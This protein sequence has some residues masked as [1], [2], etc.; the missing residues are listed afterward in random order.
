MKNLPR[1]F[2][3][4]LLAVC[5]F[6][7]NAQSA[8]DSASPFKITRSDPALDALIAPD[9]KLKTIASGFGFSDGPVWVRGQNGAPGYLLVS[10]IIRKN[11][12]QVWFLA[13]H[14]VNVPQVIAD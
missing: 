6:S 2:F 3:C 1:A 14:L 13:E 10:S 5:L 8:P 12:A 9:A 4:S 11:E 7:A